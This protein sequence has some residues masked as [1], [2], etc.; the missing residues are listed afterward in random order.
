V[1]LDTIKAIKTAL[2]ATVNDVVMAV[3]AGGL[4]TYLDRHDA[5]PDAP[6]IAMVPVSIRTGDETEKWTNRVSAIFA[7]LP[8]DEADPVKRVTR[9]HEAMGDAKRLFDAVPADTLTDSRLASGG[10]RAGDADSHSPQRARLHACKPVIPTC[11][12]RSRRHCGARLLH[13]YPVDDRRRPGLN[14]TA[15][16][17]LNTLTSVS[18]AAAYRA[19]LRTC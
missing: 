16:S 12:L 11:P 6:L 1:P 10:V 18:S 9:V 8:T 3:C 2:G 19:R 7:G 15:Q 14:I 13:H 17:H 4:R 5:L